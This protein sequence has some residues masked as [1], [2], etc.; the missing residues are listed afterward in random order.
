[1]TLDDLASTAATAYGLVWDLLHE[2]ERN[3]W[4]DVARATRDKISSPD[5]TML[6]AAVKRWRADNELNLRAMVGSIR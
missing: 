4:R 2:G 6:N 3:A 5:D 1:M